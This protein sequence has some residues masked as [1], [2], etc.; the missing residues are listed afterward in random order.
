M[1]AIVVVVKMS[2]WRC[3]MKTVLIDHGAQEPH[4]HIK[5]VYVLIPTTNQ[6]FVLKIHL[7]VIM[8]VMEI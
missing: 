7:L 6:T 4:P 2:T 1:G 8:Y 5:I 3:V